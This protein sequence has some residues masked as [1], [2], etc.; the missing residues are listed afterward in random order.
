MST[1]NVS[2]QSSIFSFFQP[3]NSQKESKEGNIPQKSIEKRPHKELVNQTEEH[4]KLE[5][6]L[7]PNKK[8]FPPN[9]KMKKNQKD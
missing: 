8:S 2:S 1:K 7:A 3:L 5:D 6:E 4:K 9:Q